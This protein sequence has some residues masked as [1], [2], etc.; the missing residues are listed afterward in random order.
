MSITEG[1][2]AEVKVSVAMITYNHERFIAQAIESV[3][4]QETDFPVE[5]VIGEDCST[6][7]TRAIVQE[8]A[9]RYPDKVKAL[10]H[11]HNL[12]PAHSPGKNNLVSVLKA[13]TGKYIALLEGDDYWTDPHKLQKQM[14]FLEAH[15]ECSLCFH[16]VK[17]VYEN[18]SRPTRDYCPPDQ[19]VISTLEDLLERNLI[20]T[21][22]VMYRWGLVKELPEWFFRLRMGDWPLHVLHAQH[23]KIGY[24]DGV[25]G[26]YRIHTD[27]LYSQS[28]KLDWLIAVFDMYAELNAHLGRKHQKRI[29]SGLW[30]ACEYFIVETV[31]N[32]SKSLSP[33]EVNRFLSTLFS[34]RTEKLPIPLFVQQQIKAKCNIA[35]GFV[36]FQRSD[37]SGA[38]RFMRNAIFHDARWLMNRGVLK[39]ALGL[40]R[41]DRH[42]IVSSTA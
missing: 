14:E 24:V 42:A 10:L 12:G 26:A 23:G 3:L 22:S 8:Y 38:R 37:L 19:K 15:P 18:L 11:P 41:P 32:S 17:M 9:A 6:D 39:I 40:K 33:S 21:C 36:C 1:T 34:R 16:N 5:L 25:M 27:S 13:C 4:M 30:Q 31:R 29:I 2:P 7:G 35:A 20:P 28:N